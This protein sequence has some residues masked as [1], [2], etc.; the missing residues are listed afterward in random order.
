MLHSKDRKQFHTLFRIVSKCRLV[1]FFSIKKIIKM[2]EQ[3]DMNYKL[4][5]KE[6][7]R[8]KLS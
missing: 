5:D 7:N 2:A 8:A 1:L 4:A 6:S 3:E